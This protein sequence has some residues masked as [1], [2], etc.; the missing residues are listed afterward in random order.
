MWLTD[1][2]NR[3]PVRIRMELKIGAAEVYLS[4]A[5]GLRYPQTALLSNGKR[6]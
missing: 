2:A 1:D 3:L 6:K 5:Q 4:S